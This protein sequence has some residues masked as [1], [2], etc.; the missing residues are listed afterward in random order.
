MR[1]PL[2]VLSV[3]LVLEFPFVPFCGAAYR[4]SAQ[5]KKG[6]DKTTAYT[7]FRI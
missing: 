5:K 6:R 7:P 1:Y 2:T 3:P 4:V